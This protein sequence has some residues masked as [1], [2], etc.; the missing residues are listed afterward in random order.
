MAQ[1]G[2][3]LDAAFGDADRFGHLARQDVDALLEAFEQPR[4]RIV[5]GQDAA[6]MQEV[7]ERAHDER[8]E[9][10]GPLR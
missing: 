10:I 7:V 9:P 4:A 8:Q 2:V 1:I 5:A 3:V 6:W